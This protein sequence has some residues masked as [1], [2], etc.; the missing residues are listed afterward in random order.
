MVVVCLEYLVV[1]LG[2]GLPRGV[3]N[4]YNDFWSVK[5]VYGFHRVTSCVPLS[6]Y[7]N[8]KARFRYVVWHDCRTP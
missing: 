7:G 5:N 2:S 3:E 8:A 4:N 1:K 6:G